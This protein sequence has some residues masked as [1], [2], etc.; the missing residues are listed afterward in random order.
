M[1]AHFFSVRVRALAGTSVQSV[2]VHR[3]IENKKQYIL[4]TYYNSFKRLNYKKFLARRYDSRFA[5]LLDS[6]S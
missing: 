5:V 3:P 6:S 2:P 1:Q 4:N